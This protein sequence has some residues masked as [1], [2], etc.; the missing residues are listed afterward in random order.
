MVLN[1]ISFS[2]FDQLF[3]LISLY[4]IAKL[5]VLSNS[6]TSFGCFDD[7]NEQYKYI[8][9]FIERHN[10]ILGL[11][12]D[13]NSVFKIANLGQI[14]TA[15]SLLASAVIQVQTSLNSAMV[16]VSG[17]IIFQLFSYCLVGEYVAKAVRIFI[18][19]LILYDISDL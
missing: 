18:Q 9:K 19:N 6:A 7:D 3:V 1:F 16:L 10:K 12:E 2:A 14:M 4:F 15:M 5:T 17:V 13:A 8:D 11:I